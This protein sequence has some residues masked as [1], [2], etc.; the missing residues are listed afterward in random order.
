[1]KYRPETRFSVHN[2]PPSQSPAA[3]PS[4]RR[5]PVEAQNAARNLFSAGVQPRQTITYLRGLVPETPLLPQ[6]IYNQASQ[7]RRDIRQG[8][9]STEALAQHLEAKGIKHDILKEDGTDRLKGLF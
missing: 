7:I 2:H 8:Y 1:V 3:H 9:S 5:L 6:D 4:H